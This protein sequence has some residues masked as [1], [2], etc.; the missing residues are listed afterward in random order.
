[1]AR[2]QQAEPECCVGADQG[3]F[4]LSLCALLL[5]LTRVS[6]R[7]SRRSELSGML[8]ADSF[9]PPLPTVRRS[10]CYTGFSQSRDTRTWM[11]FRRRPAKRGSREFWS[12][13]RRETQSQC[14]QSSTGDDARFAKLLESLP[15]ESAV[16]VLL[17]LKV[18]GMSPGRSRESHLLHPGLSIQTEGASRL[19]QA[20]T[21]G[22]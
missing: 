19:C 22:N 7:R 11:G 9:F 18:S 4:H 14:Q 16:E 10:Q 12:P 20:S 5:R 1:M 15:A 3:A 8:D 21:A 2:Y 13:I 17:M 6:C